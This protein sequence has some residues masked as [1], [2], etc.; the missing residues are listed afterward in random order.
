MAVSGAPGALIDAFPTLR[1][2]VVGEGML[3]AYLHGTSGRLCREAPVPIV[4]VEGRVDLPGGAANAAV[5][6]RA[7]GARV[8]MLSVVGDDAEGAPLRAALAARGVDVTPVLV[9]P[10]RRTLA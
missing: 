2:L 10:G 6:A 3:D 4:A 8:S 7:L 5:N 1:V 9:D